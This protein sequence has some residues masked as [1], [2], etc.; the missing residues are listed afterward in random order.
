MKKIYRFLIL[1]LL[2]VFAVPLNVNAATGSYSISSNSTVTNG[3]TFSVTFTIK[4]NKLFYWQAYISYDSSKL[5]LVSGTTVFQGE[6]DNATIGQS[7]VSKTLKFKA[8]KSGNAYVAI[9]MGDK[10]VNINADIQEVSFRKVTKTINIKNKVVKNYSSNNYL[11]SLSVEGYNLSPAFNKNT[12]EYNI[13]VPAETKNIKVSAEKE[14]SASKI[15]GLGNR[16]LTEG[17]NKI[18]VKVTAENG[19]V[20][21]YT[22]NVKVKELDPIYVEINKEKFSVIRK[23]SELPTSISNVY[24]KST[25]DIDNNKVPCLINTI[26]KKVLIALKNQNG[27]INL[28]LYDSK[29]NTY[30]LYNEITFN[31]LILYPTSKP[32]NKKGF[33]KSTLVLNDKNVEAYKNIENPDYY[34]FYGINIESGEENIYSYDKKENTVQ[35]FHEKNNSIKKNIDSNNLYLYT[36][37]GLGSVLL[38]TYITLII[39]LLKKSSNKKKDT[40]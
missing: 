37:I 8:T 15:E 12:N 34:I 16:E 9:A 17:L 31:K 1:L 23:E 38:I 7:S 5:Q 35:R 4:A 10:G 3:N 19:G 13:E 32:V 14:D 27:D 29:E 2:L 21:Q 6:S 36:T 11:K 39:S 26:T 33:T 18:I 20:R 25:I 40:K 30:N 24:E 22:L 28:Y